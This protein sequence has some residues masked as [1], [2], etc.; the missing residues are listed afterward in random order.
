MI[1]YGS[2]M[3]LILILLKF[4]F[5][6]IFKALD[7]CVELLE[8]EPDS[9]WTLYTKLLILL[10]LDSRDNHEVSSFIAQQKIKWITTRPVARIGGP[11]ARAPPPLF[12]GQRWAHYLNQKRKNEKRKK[13]KKEKKETKNEKRGENWHK[14]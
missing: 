5:M 3:L 11:Q 1:F 9:K 7:N 2:I 4:M 10:N 12:K 14:I 8:L 6:Y 13:G